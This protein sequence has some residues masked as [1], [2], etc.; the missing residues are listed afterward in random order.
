MKVATKTEL[1]ASAGNEL[2]AHVRAF[3]AGKVSG[4][5]RF[6][7]YRQL[8]DKVGGIPLGAG[9]I[10]SDVLRATVEAGLPRGLTL[11]VARADGTV[12]FDSAEEFKQF[13][14]NRRNALGLRHDV[15]AHD[16]SDVVFEKR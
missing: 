13:D 12:D 15:L 10:L 7:S 9:R 11:F 16:W 2:V 14:M 6:L 8:T 3:Q 1:G 5:N 4:R